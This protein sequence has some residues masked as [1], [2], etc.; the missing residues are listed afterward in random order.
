MEK[1]LCDTDILSALAK[2][3]ALDLIHEAL[4]ATPAITEYVYDELERSREAGFEFPGRIFEA[5]EVTTMDEKEAAAY[6]RIRE[7]NDHA[8]LSSTDIKNIVVARER[9]MILLSNDQ[10]ALRRTEREDVLALDIYDLSRKAFLNGFNEAELNEIL[11]A[12]EKKDNT[13][14]KHREK[15]FE[16]NG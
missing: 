9:G 5:V 12:I 7:R 3:D 1:V 8:G 15:I 2:A 13:L 4:G 11:D 6:L 10:L 16:G 14:L